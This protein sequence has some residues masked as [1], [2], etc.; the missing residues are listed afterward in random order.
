MAYD[1][2]PASPT[3]V[4][5]IEY[6]RHDTIDNT[7][8]MYS[9]SAGMRLCLPYLIIKQI[10]MQLEIK[11]RWSLIKSCDNAP[12]PILH[13]ERAPITVWFTYYVK[14]IVHSAV[15]YMKPT[16]PI[17]YLSATYTRRSLSIGSYSLVKKGVFVPLALRITLMAFQGLVLQYQWPLLWKGNMEMLARRLQTAAPRC[18]YCVYGNCSGI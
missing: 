1:E 14:K 10:V 13:H 12:V 4:P 18:R 17:L 8:T 7:S 6:S 11:D 5:S 9:E 16:I 2:V 15:E 3:A